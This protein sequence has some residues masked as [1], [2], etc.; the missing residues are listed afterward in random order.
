MHMSSL[1]VSIQTGN[2]AEIR[3]RGQRRQVSNNASGG[4]TAQRWISRGSVF[5]RCRGCPPPLF[6]PDV[7]LWQGVVPAWCPGSVP[8]NRWVWP[9]GCHMLVIVCL[10]CV[11]CCQNAFRHWF[12]E[13]AGGMGDM[14]PPNFTSENQP[15]GNNLETIPTKAD[16][17]ESIGGLWVW[18]KKPL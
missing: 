14:Q 17:R 16:G 11:Q 8:R 18:R 3:V 9:L 12:V 7:L 15:A 2:F 10:C 6:P 13:E 4:N 1:N 5:G